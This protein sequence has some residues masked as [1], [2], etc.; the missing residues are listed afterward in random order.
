MSKFKRCHNIKYVKI[1]KDIKMK[2][3]SE[4]TKFDNEK[5]VKMEKV[6]KCTVKSSVKNVKI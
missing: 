6:L 4:Y 3:M 5:N 1:W 2:K